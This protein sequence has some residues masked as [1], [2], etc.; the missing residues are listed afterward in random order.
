MMING[1]DGALTID[2]LAE[3]TGLSVRNIRAYQSRRLLQSPEIRGRV[4]YYGQQHV[5]RIELVQRLQGEGFNLQA[6]TALVERGDAFVLGVEQLRRD[7][8]ADA[9]DGWIPMTDEEQRLCE[10]N[11]PGSLERFQLIGTIRVADDG[12]L[13]THPQL[14]EA[15]WA[16]NLLGVGP[17][18]IIDLLFV[19]HQMIRRV[20]DVYVDV[21]HERLVA[22]GAD[23]GA[24]EV[25]AIRGVF[26]ELTPH[27]VQ[28][29]TT[30]FEIVLRKE[31]A[32]SLE[33]T[34]RQLPPAG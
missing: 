31:A 15:G 8:R 32:Q 27:A 34:I 9:A 28:I 6:I 14:A 29:M 19:T 11:S 2:Q 10:E 22:T 3:V 20:G 30:L 24:Q 21:L 25:R 7:L 4:G 23:P 33:R 18:T 17:E 26:E 13:M 1:D 16:L 5:T 12:R